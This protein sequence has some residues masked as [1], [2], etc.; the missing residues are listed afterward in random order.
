MNEHQIETS[1][2]VICYSGNDSNKEEPF[3]DADQRHSYE[4]LYMKAANTADIRMVRACIEWF[5]GEVFQSYWEFE[6]E[7]WRYVE[8]VLT[9]TVVLDKTE[10]DFA[11]L[12][13][14]MQLSEKYLV[15]N[16]WELDLL[17]SDKLLTETAFS[18]YA[19]PSRMVRTRA[20]ALTAM[21]ELGGDEFVY[22]PRLGHGG[23]GI[24]FCTRDS[25]QELPNDTLALMQPVIDTSAGIPGICDSIHDLRIVWI[26]DEPKVAFVRFPAPGGRL[27]NLSQG[28]SAKEVP[29]AD[30]PQSLLP[31]FEGLRTKLSRFHSVMYSTDFFFDAA[32]TPYLI[33][34]NTKPIIAF[35]PAYLAL[36]QKIQGLYIEA[37]KQY[38]AQVQ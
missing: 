32:G 2:V 29:L 16:P 33:E 31:I 12:P 22:K 30:L 14:K 7:V 25:A 5:D 35:P 26:D 18:E 3:S 19:I 20:E 34:I 4:A 11:L 13:K 21:D 37:L 1:V 9:P 38:C 8:A 15:I 27:C 6:N 10:L 17:A 24:Q 28:G 36:E 23:K